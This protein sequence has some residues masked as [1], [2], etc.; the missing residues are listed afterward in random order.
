MSDISDIWKSMQAESSDGLKEFRRRSSLLKQKQG[1]VTVTGLISAT[2]KDPKPSKAETQYAERYGSVRKPKKTPTNLVAKELESLTVSAAMKTTPSELTVHEAEAVSAERQRV[3][4]QDA[5]GSLSRDLHILAEDTVESKKK[6]LQRIHKYLFV[7]CTMAATDFAEVFHEMCKPIFRTFE[8]PSEKCRE[9][10]FKITRDFFLVVSDLVPVLG[11][12]VPALMA[13]VPSGAGFDEEMKVFISNLAEHEEYRRG[14]AVERQDMKGV[15]GSVSV[16]VIET[17]EEIRLL[18]VSCVGALVNKLIRDSSQSIIHPYFHELIMFLQAQLRDTFPDVK[19]EASRILELLAGQEDFVPGMKFFAVALTRALLP[20]LRHRH[21]KVRLQALGAVKACIAVPDRAKRKGAG[22][23]A[24]TDLVGFREENV[25]PIAAFY[26]NAVQVNYIAEL[27][28]DPSI[29]VREKLVE[30]LTVFLCDIGDRYDHQTRLLPYLLDLLTDE[31]EAVSTPALACLK[32]CGQEYEDE[33]RDEIIERRQYGVDG[34]NRMNLDKPLPLPFKERPRIGIRLYVRGNTKRFISALVNE[35]TC[36]VS[37]TRVKSAQLLKMVIIL[38]EEHLT[39][40]AFSLLPSFIKAL[41]FARTDGDKELHTELLEV[42]ELLGR[43]M[44]PEV[45]I[46]YIMPRLRGD[47]DVIAFGTD[48]LFRTTVL[49]FLNALLSGSKPSQ[50]PMHFSEI[51]SVLTDPFVIDPTSEMLRNATTDVIMSLLVALSGRGQAAAIESHF[52]ATGRLT[53][54]NATLQKCF[55]FFVLDLSN[56][57]LQQKATEC[58][59]ILSSFEAG[60]AVYHETKMFYV[61]FSKRGSNYLQTLI[62]EFDLSDGWSV[63]SSEYRTI[64][65]LVHCPCRLLFKNLEDKGSL[66]IILIDFLCRAVEKCTTAKESNEITLSAIS[67]T[68]LFAVKN[69]WIESLKVHDRFKLFNLFDLKESDKDENLLDRSHLFSLALPTLRSRLGDLISV[70]VHNSHWSLST[71]LQWSR[72]NLMNAL[73]CTEDVGSSILNAESISI[74]SHLLFCSVLSSGRQPSNPVSLRL[75]SLQLVSDM[76]TTLHAVIDGGEDISRI[77]VKWSED[78]SVELSKDLKFSSS[79][80]SS[81]EALSL[82][83]IESL[84]DADDAVR[85]L[86][87]QCLQKIL[88][89]TPESSYVEKCLD[90]DTI[91]KKI[92]KLSLRIVKTAEAGNIMDGIDLLLRSMASINPTYVE[93]LVR[94]Y[95]SESASSGCVESNDFIQFC[96]DIISHCDIISQFRCIK[97]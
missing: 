5:L 27:V 43:Y 38:C 26:T 59:K 76:L 52:L 66:L 29:S 19:I 25:L 94:E 54:M 28:S 91:P 7:D 55:E 8:S 24:I 13:R 37:K 83:L 67:K 45:Y 32:R 6:A 14:R 68:L 41:G 96:S 81:I 50:L 11:Y 56:P 48:N 16:N 49:E 22:T 18:A 93:N 72:V 47:P 35:L 61:L 80:V 39:M 86:A 65:T 40:E 88:I 74:F 79:S 46:H 63:E 21:A 3:T 75:A 23:D 58:L 60:S 97:K 95:L 64:D 30:T 90:C 44:S 1:G 71:S 51:I 10:A 2:D 62:Q 36:W 4:A 89:F 31:C 85:Y 20:C 57:V 33:H 34:D 42:Y 73:I 12:F 69:N 53:S 78:G 87:V 70:F 77:Q 17:S 9:L 15:V 92:A 84:D 82:L